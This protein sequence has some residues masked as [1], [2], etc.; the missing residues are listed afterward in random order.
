MK[1]YVVVVGGLNIDIAGLS[2]DVYREKDSNIGEVTI[3]IGGV[4]QNIAQNLTKLGTPTYLVTVYGDDSFGKIAQMECKKNKI[5]LENAEQIENSRSSI[6]LYVNDNEGDLV[7]GINDMKICENITPEFLAKRLDFI[8]GAKIVVVDCNLSQE[9]IE[10][11]CENVTSPI[12]V[13][14]VSVA[15][16]DRV[17]NVLDK[18]HTLKPNELEAELLTGIKITDE[19]TAREAAKALNEKGVKNVYISLGAQGILCAKEGEAVLV[20]PLAKEIVSTNGAGDCSMATLVWARFNYGEELPL[21]EVG[22]YTQAAASINVESPLAV[23]PELN[24]EEVLK[25]AEE[26]K[27]N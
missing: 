22:I 12:Y 6:Y 4:G 24:V 16:V 11:L 3:N 10:W 1:D 23:S 2:G 27:K 9:S 8:N 20:K 5:G 21:E 14:P 7:T 18:I 25:R 19:A 15:K 13:D 17:K 26:G